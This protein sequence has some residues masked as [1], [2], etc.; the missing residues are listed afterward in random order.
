MNMTFDL[1]AE[2]VEA[3]REF[4]DADAFVEG[5]L[6]R[7]IKAVASSKS[8]G[9]DILHLAGRLKSH[10]PLLD[11]RAEKDAAKEMFVA[12]EKRFLRTHG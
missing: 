7:E 9:R 10:E 1:S 12:R 4:P 11:I 5:V 3:L 8:S 6:R 2:T